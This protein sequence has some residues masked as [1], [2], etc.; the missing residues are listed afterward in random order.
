[1]SGI[2]IC[3]DGTTIGTSQT[4]NLTALKSNRKMN[5]S[6]LFRQSCLQGRVV[7]QGHFCFLGA[8]PNKGIMLLSA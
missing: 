2:L 7:V 1:M 8:M 6:Q 3:M 4:F 5:S